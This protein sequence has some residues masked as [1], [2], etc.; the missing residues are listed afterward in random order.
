F[1]LVEKGIANGDL[2][3]ELDPDLATYIIVT[4]SNNLRYFIPEKLAMDTHQLAKSE[5]IN[6]D[7]Q[8]VEAIYDQLIQVFERGM[9][10]K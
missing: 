7:M 5:E 8:A 9:G 6:I 2:R 4:A 3:P 10:S 1:E